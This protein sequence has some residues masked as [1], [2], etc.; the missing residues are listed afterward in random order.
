MPLPQASA[1]AN[2]TARTVLDTL[3]AGPFHLSPSDLAWV[4][5]TRDAM[6]TDDKLRQLFILVSPA[7]DLADIDRLMDLRPAGVHCMVGRDFDAAWHCAR[8]ILERAG[9]PPFIT[10]D[11]EG[12][13]HGFPCCTPLPNPLGLAAAD[14]LAL[15]R[16][17]ASVVAREGR[18]LGFNW[19]FTPVADISAAI[20]SAIVGTRSFGSNIDT[21]MAQ[22]VTHVQALQ[23]QG[24]AATAKHWPGEGHDAR[25][26][27]LVTT[28]NPLSQAEWMASYGRIYRALFD[29][30]VMTVMSA[31]IAWPAWLQRT[32][33]GLATCVPA[34]LSPE[35]NQDLLRREL[36]FNGLVVSDATLMAGL[37]SWGDRATV[38]PQVI[39]SGCDLFLFSRHEEADIAH[40]REG[41]R[42][43]RLSAQRLEDAVTRVLGLKAAL[44][45]H[46]KSIDERLPPLAQ[47][48]SMVRS[49]A[50][51]QVAEQA[52]A[53][54]VTL[55]KDVR[56][57]LPLSP[58]TH[59]RVLVLSDEGCTPV[60]GLAPR[61]LNVLLDGL[62]DA[63]FALRRF[64]PEHE[65]SAADTD[66]VL[67]LLGQE[68]MLTLS[69]IHIDWRRLQPGLLQSMER[70]WHDIP[71]VMVS[72]G[73]PYHLYDAP[74][75]P[76]YINAYS[77]VEPMQRAVLRKLLGTEPFDG[78]SPVDALCGLPDA[79]W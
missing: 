23:A 13:G 66:L 36:G 45:L 30:G 61:S 16:E 49:A 63:G 18:A 71:T 43:G 46:R 2:T 6:S 8:R 4:R 28:V 72:F 69:R 26:Q 64:D 42:S 57:T 62:R 70:W 51:Q 50:H 32:T 33:S 10:G 77:A 14:D 48:R 58:H 55:V 54:S 40:M 11:L 76:V 78:R 35:L 15:S 59:R 60:P 5:R 53:A 24:L 38:V 39:E 12:G 19:S 31:H 21:I 79:A 3:S 34:C 29:A 68:S 20:A 73:H 52:A 44:G 65:P 37:S 56:A 74:R 22:C 1:S 7:S 67:Y 25:D 47:A 27:H 75:V 17:V 41:L 9:V